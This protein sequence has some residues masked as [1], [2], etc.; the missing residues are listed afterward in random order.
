METLA[1]DCGNPMQYVCGRSPA[2][3]FYLL[4][5]HASLA[6]TMESKCVFLNSLTTP[7]PPRVAR[8]DK[9]KY[10]LFSVLC[11]LYPVL[12]TLFSVPCSL[13]PVLCT[14]FSVPCS[15]YSVLCTLFSVLCSLKK[16][17]RRG[18]FLISCAVFLFFPLTDFFNP[19]IQQTVFTQVG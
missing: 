13:Y 4:D 16:T 2:A 18:V 15:L 17:P 6:M 7:P 5:R 19:I 1:Y 3:L 9:N 12:C 10:S 8:N 14:L 11:S